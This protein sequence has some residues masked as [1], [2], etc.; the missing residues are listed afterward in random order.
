[1]NS[2]LKTELL[3]AISAVLSSHGYLPASR[4]Q[5]RLNA[6]SNLTVAFQ[7]T[8]EAAARQRVAH[9]GMV[10]ET[11]H[12]KSNHPFFFKGQKLSLVDFDPRDKGREWKATNGLAVVELSSP[13][14]HA[15]VSRFSYSGRPAVVPK[16][17]EGEKATTTVSPVAV[18]TEGGNAEARAAQYATWG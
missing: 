12:W 7:T 5:M 17:P 1:M 14:I 18:K 16:L 3:A 4:I 13:D 10:L 2:E 6:G 8:T 9:Y 11:E 15:A